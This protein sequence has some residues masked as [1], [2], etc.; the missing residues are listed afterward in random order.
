MSRPAN[1]AYTVRT[2]STDTNYPAGGNPWNGQATKVEPPGPAG[3]FVPNQGAAAEYVNKL[4]NDAYTIDSNTKTSLTN[5]A[6][7]MG[8]I[9]A[10]NF[11]IEVSGP[12]TTN[13]WAVY[14]EGLRR[15]Y[16]SGDNEKLYYSVDNIAWTLDSAIATAIVSGA[17][18]NLR[19][20]EA[21]PSGNMVVTM[22]DIGVG[23][24][25]IAQMTGSSGAWT[26]VDVFGATMVNGDTVPVVY[27]PINGKWIVVAHASGGVTRIA[28]SANRT[29]WTVETTAAAHGST[30]FDAT[31]LSLYRLA[32]KKSTGRVVM[33]AFRSS[34]TRI[35]VATSDDGGNTWTDRSQFTI[36]LTPLTE[37]GCELTYNPDTN[38]FML[39]VFETTG[40]HSSEL[41]TSSDGISW[42][43]A[44]AFTNYAV[45]NVAPVGN[46]W[47]AL[48]SNTT[49]NEVIYSL[50]NGA[51]WYF[52]GIQTATGPLGVF[53]GV[54]RPLILTDTKVRMGFAA[55]LPTVLGS[56]T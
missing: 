36:G 47:A 50:D 41:W 19:R 52:A 32:C 25:Y 26:E 16:I 13:F 18:A 33:T 4:F 46:M 54:S 3:G 15:W 34:D 37:R 5:W 23:G 44:K 27:D 22:S 35:V 49:V 12:A 40:T 48:A 17:A 43:L 56:P 20:F 45:R 10:L 51:T 7:F 8:Q 6:N 31:T 24:R 38:T 11:P 39:V 9:Q 55:G 30:N 2:W 29:T 21:D 42:S 28:T 53:Y 14:N 1:P